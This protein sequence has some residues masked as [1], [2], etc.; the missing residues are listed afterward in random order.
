M[1]DV[2]KKRWSPRKFQD[3][4]VVPEMVEKLFDVARWSASSYNEQPWRFYVGYNGDETYQKIYESLV[5]FNQS[6]NTNTPVLILGIVKKSFSHTD[7]VNEHAKY[8]LGQSMAYFSAA[9]TN[10]GLFVHQMAGFSVKKVQEL[11]HIPEGYEAAVVASLGYWDENEKE[12]D[13]RDN[14]RTRKGLSEILF[15]EHWK[16]DLRG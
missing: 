10:E 7:S 8:D 9:A 1:I 3:K 16:R 12:A 14:K 5:E 2:L 13:F 15:G 6:W 11:F 4:K